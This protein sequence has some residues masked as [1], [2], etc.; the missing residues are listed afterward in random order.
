ME[1]KD[2]HVKAAERK[3]KQQFL[4]EEIIESHYD[5][6]LFLEFSEQK[7]SS[8]I[9]QWEFDEL[10]ECVR[11]FKLKYR[12]G[13]TYEE[14]LQQRNK[15]NVESNMV[16]SEEVEGGRIRKDEAGGIQENAKE[17]VKENKRK[18]ATTGEIVFR[19]HSKDSRE[20]YS[21]P[22]EVIISGTKVQK[23]I[24]SSM[25]KIKILVCNPEL[26]DPGLFSSK[27]YEFVVNTQ[28]VNW[29]VKR[30]IDEFLWIREV[31]V[32]SYPGIF[33]P[34]LSVSSSN[35]LEPKSIYKRIVYFT[36]F[37][38]NVVSDPLLRANEQLLAFLKEESLKNIMKSYKKQKKIKEASEFKSLDGE[39]SCLYQESV[40]EYEAINLYLFRADKILNDLLEQFKLLICD[41]IKCSDDIKSYSE[42]LQELESANH[43]IGNDPACRVYSE[44]KNCLVKWSEFLQDN[45]KN[46]YEDLKVPFRLYKI[47]LVTL[48]NLIK[49]REAAWLA[50]AGSLNKPNSQTLK[51][52]YGYINSKCLFSI[53]KVLDDVTEQL[54]LRLIQGFR[55]KGDQSIEFHLVWGNLILSL[56]DVLI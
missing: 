1:G 6:N 52:I 46:I 27:Y 35:K 36:S 9:D 53:K 50:Y 16:R 7:K 38:N 10:A 51:D 24:L 3:A 47:E 26:I 29:I 11:L 54:K 18:E 43:I 17:K 45:T 4:F 21:D 48:K 39:I 33:I 28:P 19:D 25:D 40:Q 15:S 31:L 14:V 55:K 8:D 42:I 5:S 2:E 32:T 20:G 41:H 49:E 44:L 12:P 22:A 23:T 37:L 34:P 13:Q 30:K 56:A